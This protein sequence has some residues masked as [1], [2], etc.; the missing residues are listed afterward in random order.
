MIETKQELRQHVAHVL[1]GTCLYDS[2]PALIADLLTDA[3]WNDRERT[4]VW[5]GKTDLWD[6][7]LKSVDW[8]RLITASD[9]RIKREISVLGRLKRILTGRTQ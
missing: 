7:S 1:M 3:L 5:T 6:N 4:I 2:D 8:Q 9:N